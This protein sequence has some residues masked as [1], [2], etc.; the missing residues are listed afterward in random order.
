MKYDGNLFDLWW[1][2][3]T[4]AASMVAMFFTILTA[5][6]RGGKIIIVTVVAWLVALVML[7][8]REGWFDA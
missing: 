5:D 4:V 2:L 8:I 1:D 3:G 7:G 6:T